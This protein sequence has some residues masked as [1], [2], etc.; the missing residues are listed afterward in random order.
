M[1]ELKLGAGA[2]VFFLCFGCYV[3][4]HETVCHMFSMWVLS[5]GG[6]RQHACLD[7]EG[8]GEGGSVVFTEEV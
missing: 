7:H 1:S 4:S 5:S 3:A 2:L 6:Q 8:E